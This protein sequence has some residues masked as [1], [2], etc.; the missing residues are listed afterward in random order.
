[1]SV[2]GFDFGNTNLV[3][4]LAR[5]GGIDVVMNEVSS[6]LTPALV[7]FDHQQRHIGASGANQIVSNAKNTISD[8]KRFI[9]RRFYEK[10]LQKELE[11]V[12]YK[13]VD[14]GDGHLGMQVNYQ[15]EIQTFTPEKVAAML[16]V[17]M[18]NIADMNNS[19]QKVTDCVISAP[20]YWTDSQRRA[21][22]DAAEIAGLHC[23]RLMNETTAI[24]LGYGIVKTDLPEKDPI[25]LMFV[26]MGH[27]SLQV[28]VAS[29]IKGEVTILATGY[30]RD[31][32]G[33]DFDEIL[34]NHFAE[35]WKAKHKIDI[36]TNAKA[37][38]RTRLMAEK[39]KKTLSANSEAGISVEC[40]M[41]EIDVGG[42]M[43]RVDFEA[44]CT[45]LYERIK[46]T[47]LKTLEASGV[48]KDEVR[49]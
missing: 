32:G 21:M 3:V 15:N 22:L 16:L 9:G 46:A 26:D 37:L 4:G 30:D 19:G 14:I 2:A 44:L 38:L 48:S 29:F 11:Y 39:M 34:V 6:R 17:C 49:R 27:S 45:P 5:R 42:N 36:R 28:A 35:Q 18:K 8:L 24:A 47:L 33:R 13:V 7:S 12:Q 1:M 25:K 23:L 41:N 40:V 43:K 20:V 31:L 10:D